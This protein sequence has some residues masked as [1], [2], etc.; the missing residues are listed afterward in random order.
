MSHVQSL[1]RLVC[2][3]TDC[4]A[5]TH[6]GFALVSGRD[7]EALAHLCWVAGMTEAQAREHVDAAFELWAQRSAVAWAL[8]LGIL[9][10]AG[11]T[12]TPPPSPDERSRPAQS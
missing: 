12:V 4:H 8:D 3:C 6:F 1:R 9:T 10:D 2:L 7:A 5:A 11:V